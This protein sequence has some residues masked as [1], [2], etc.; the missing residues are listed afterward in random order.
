MI[1]IVLGS[2]S[3]ALLV[4]LISL[5]N[6]LVSKNNRV[7]TAWADIDVQLKRRY[8][9]VPN[10]VE[11]VKGYKDYEASVLEKVTAARTS[12]IATK[13]GSNLAAKIE[14]ETLFAGALTNLFALA[15]NYPQL[16]SS[17]NFKQ[18]Q[19][20]LTNLEDNIQSARRY[21]NAAVREFNNATQIFPS[22]MIAMAFSFQPGTFFGAE[23]SEKAPVNVSFQNDQTK[24]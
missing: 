3:I 18:L 1:H 4:Y 12:A 21:Y 14:A 20:E 13:S 10:L 5:F 23:E 2:L 22:N 17:E 19:S 7:K 11:T 8:D 9:L 15:E 24:K 16:K 6:K